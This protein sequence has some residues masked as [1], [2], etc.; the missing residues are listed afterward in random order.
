MADGQQPPSI[1]RARGRAR[2]QPRTEEEMAQMR[3]PGEATP[4]PAVPQP[5]QL[6]PGRGRGVSGDRGRG[7]SAAVHKFMMFGATLNPTSGMAKEMG[8]VLQVIIQTASFQ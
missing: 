7:T 5:S 3:R 2:G 8:T 1:G 6:P 4:A